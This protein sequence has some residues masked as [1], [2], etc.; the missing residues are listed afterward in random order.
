MIRT[1]LRLVA[2]GFVLAAAIADAGA[3]DRLNLVFACTADNDLFRVLSAAET[4]YPRYSSAAEAVARRRR[5]P[6]C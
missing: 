2:T 3:A 4:P 1:I 5:A 6:G